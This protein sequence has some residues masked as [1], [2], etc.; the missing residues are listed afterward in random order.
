MSSCSIL[1]FLPNPQTQLDPRWH[2]GSAPQ[3]SKLGKPFS[4][5][6]LHIKG[7]RHHDLPVSPASSPIVILLSPLLNHSLS[8]IP[9]PF[10]GSRF[11]PFTREV[12]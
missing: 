10:P 3:S 9:S 1:V 12:L 11:L 7:I 6:Y 5:S 8:S 4:L 2:P